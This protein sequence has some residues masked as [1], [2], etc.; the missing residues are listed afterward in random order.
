MG[1][2]SGLCHHQGRLN[3]NTPVHPLIL[4]KLTN[5]MAEQYS[6]R[7]QS[8]VD[9]AMKLYTNIRKYELDIVKSGWMEG[10]DGRPTKPEITWGDLGTY[11]DKFAKETGRTPWKP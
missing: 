5:L 9:Q 7:G 3:M 2:S 11:A 1:D 4:V 10:G 6:L 8:A